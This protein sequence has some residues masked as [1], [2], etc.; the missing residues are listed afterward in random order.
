M[1]A[2][3]GRS[4]L[5]AAPGPG[6]GAGRSVDGSTPPWSPVRLRR[7]GLPPLRFHGRVIARY[8]GKVPGA[9]LWHDIALYQTA[10]AGFGIE[11]VAQLLLP[12]PEAPQDTSGAGLVRPAR[13]H[14][15][16]F[17]RLEDALTS[18]ECHDASRDICPGI[19]AP[20]VSFGDPAV[21]PA[22]LVMQAAFL[23]GFCRD[24]VR[25]YRIGVGV[26]LADIGLRDV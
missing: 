5:T 12:G 17:N 13:C 11:I 24:V 2:T 23:Q 22:M 3:F 4:A 7:D 21:P 19:S 14:A 15:A 6:L 8:D 20:S 25:R 9:T 10:A 16:A 1:T 18:L 26:L